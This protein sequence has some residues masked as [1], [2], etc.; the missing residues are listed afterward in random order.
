MKTNFKIGERVKDLVV[1]QNLI[2]EIVLVIPE[3][4]TD[5][6]GERVYPFNYYHIKLDSPLKT[7]LNN[8]DIIG[9]AESEIEL[10]KQDL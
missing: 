10:F 4:D 3:G 1:N 7:G 9:R 6:W 5:P 2:G 8:I